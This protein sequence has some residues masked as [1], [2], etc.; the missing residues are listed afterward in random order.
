MLNQIKSIILIGFLQILINP[1]TYSQPSGFV[2]LKDSKLVNGANQSIQL[3]GINLGGWLMWE[4]WIW[5]GNFNREKLVYNKL[6]QT[7]G[8]EKAKWF[9]QEV[10]KKYIQKEDIK[11][12]SEMGFNV[13]R[14]PI[15]HLVL[16]GDLNEPQYN[17]NGFCLIDSVLLWC[18]QFNVYA[19]LDLHGA[20][21]GQSGIFV[22]DYD[23]VKLWDSENNKKKTISL[24]YKLAKRYANRTIIG[25]YDLINESGFVNGKNLVNMYK[26][27][28]DTIRTVDKN[29]L[30]ILEGKNLASSFSCFKKTLDNNQIFSFHFY[31]WYKPKLL[32]K[33]QL[34]SL[35]KFSKKIGVPL[36][37]GE[38]GEDKISILKENKKLMEDSLNNFCGIAFWTWKKVITNKNRQPLIEIKTNKE[39][40]QFIES[41]KS[42]KKEVY[43]EKI[44]HDF[45]KDMLYENN[46]PNEKMKELL[47]VTIN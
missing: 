27:I 9:R 29:H 10:Y 45:L 4:G 3:N 19:V 7:F 32:K 47:N 33:R 16:E 17:E 8:E 31:P 24:W 43:S 38:W 42:K 2:H 18:E 6:E 15:N 12:I 13:V 22:S 14:I 34:K 30:I 40:L 21:G 37:C 44:L 41:A 39:W 20:A 1:T 23:D 26:A 11:A 28:I 46:I 5:G 35:N 25:G 36:W